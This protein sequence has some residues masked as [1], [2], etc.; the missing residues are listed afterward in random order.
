MQMK[1]TTCDFYSNW[2]NIKIS[3]NL[4]WQNYGKISNLALH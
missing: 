3:N 4:C 1:A 2:K